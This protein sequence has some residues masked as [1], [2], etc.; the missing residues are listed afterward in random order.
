MFPAYESMSGG[1]GKPKE[2]S[3]VSTDVASDLEASLPPDSLRTGRS[4]PDARVQTRPDHAGD[5]RVLP[6]DSEPW[7]GR[8]GPPVGGAMNVGQ[9]LCL[10]QTGEE[11]AAKG[12]LVHH[13]LSLP[14]FYTPTR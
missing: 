12:S 14:G 10:I 11:M 3:T 9:Q 2:V 6:H 4:H 13:S 1:P 5:P 8:A 7:Q